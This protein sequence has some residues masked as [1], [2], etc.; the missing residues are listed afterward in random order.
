MGYHAVPLLILLPM[1]ERIQ[2]S[3]ITSID[4]DKSI[5]S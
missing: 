2:R 5:L 4:I 1:E 3:I